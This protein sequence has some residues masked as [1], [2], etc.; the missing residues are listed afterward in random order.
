MLSIV[1]FESLPTVKI[2]CVARAICSLC[3]EPKPLCVEKVGEFLSLI[4]KLKT[5]SVIVIRKV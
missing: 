1:N 3:N 5:R 4:D 2:Y